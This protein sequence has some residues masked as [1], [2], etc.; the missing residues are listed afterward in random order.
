[1][2]RLP[3][4]PSW[5]GPLGAAAALALLG[6]VGCSTAALFGL[7]LPPRQ[8]FDLRRAPAPP[9]YAD[10]GAWAARPESADRADLAPE[11]PGEQDRQATAPI[12]VF[13]VHPTTFYRASGWNQRLDDVEVNTLTDQLILAGQASAFNGCCRV[14]APHYRQATLGAYFVDAARAAP[15]FRLAYRDVRAAF[16]YYLEHLNQGRPFILASHSQGSMHGLR[17]LEELAGTPARER[18][19]AAYLIGYGV[20]LD[21]FETSLRAVP[22]CR[23]EADTG[24]VVAWDT[25]VDRAPLPERIGTLHWYGAR[26]RTLERDGAARPSLCVNPFTWLQ[27]GGPAS[28]APHSG[29]LLPV[30]DEPLPSLPA[31]V[32]GASIARYRISRL[33]APRQEVPSARCQESRLLVPRVA[34]P[35]LAAQEIDGSY[36]NIDYALFYADIRHN[37]QVRA[38]A[39]L[40]RHPA[41][42]PTQAAVSPVR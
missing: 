23:G 11:R 42:G 20:P 7:L 28:A 22:P 38:R 31:F 18:L 26:L 15:A 36:H 25:Y 40:A 5:R 4:G 19:V 12:D 13:F 27:D 8:A 14:Y 9:D 34:D 17:L 33:G 39:F 30:P 24:C 41:A 2:K 3:R 10:P 29:A 6:G 21:K 35:T 37:A 32:L 1:M 16:D